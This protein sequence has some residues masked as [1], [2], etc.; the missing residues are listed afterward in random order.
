MRVNPFEFRAGSVSPRADGTAIRA[1]LVMIKDLAE[2]RFELVGHSDD[3]G[4]P[5]ANLRLSEQRADAARRMLLARGVAR[6][7]LE[8]SGRAHEEPLDAAPT[9]EARAKNRRVELRVAPAAAE[10]GVSPPA[11]PPTPAL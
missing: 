11:P 3:Q 10:A 4:T 7:R 2:T 9:K 1:A 8:F 6:D 5:K